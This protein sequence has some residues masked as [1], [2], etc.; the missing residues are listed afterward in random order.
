MNGSALFICLMLWSASAL[1]H[2]VH[3]S[4]GHG[5]L[6][7]G[8]SEWLAERGVDAMA[9]MMGDGVCAA[10][11]RHFGAK[12]NVCPLCPPPAARAPAAP[13]ISFWS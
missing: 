1:H 6:W 10:P 12:H 13:C 11:A 5:W 2:K 4:S 7:L 8:C 3:I 9:G